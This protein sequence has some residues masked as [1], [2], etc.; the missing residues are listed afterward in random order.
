MFRKQRSPVALLCRDGV[1]WPVLPTRCV[2]FCLEK[3]PEAAHSPRALQKAALETG[4]LKSSSLM[5]FYLWINKI[6]EISGNS[7]EHFFFFFFA[8]AKSPIPP[9]LSIKQPKNVLVNAVVQHC[10]IFTATFP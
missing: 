4:S 1:A 7:P 10:D 2:V 3:A 6:V 8:T 5:V 9:F